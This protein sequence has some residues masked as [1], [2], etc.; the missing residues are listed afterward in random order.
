MRNCA[1]IVRY[2]CCLALPLLIPS[3]VSLAAQQDDSET[4][5]PARAE[6]AKAMKKAAGDKSSGPKRFPE[7]K[8]VIKDMK[9][10]EGLFTLYRYD[11]KDKNRDPEKLLAK[12]PARL[13]KEDMLFATS[14]SRGGSFTG[15][16]WSDHLIRW[17]IAG[18]HL[19]MIVPD[20][21]YVVKKGK[22]ISDAIKR[23]YNAR[24]I[25]TAQIVT[26]SGSDPVIDLG[27]LLKS[28]LADV[29]FMGGSIRRE[30]SKWTKTKVFPD[31]ILIDVD[32]AMSARR[33][34]GALAGLFGGGAPAKGGTTL[35]VSYTFRRLPKLGSYKPRKADDR[36]GYF[37]TAQMDLTK[38]SEARDTFDRYIN[39]WNLE[40]RD[41]SLELSPPKKPVTYIIEKTVPVQWRRWVRQGIL[42][43]NKA[44]EEIGIVDA[45]VVQQQTEDNEFA[46]YDPEDSRY[47]FFRWIVSGRAFAMGPS[48]ADPRTGQILDADIIM[49]DAMV[50]VWMTDFDVF[51]PS[52]VAEFK[53]PGFR[54]YVERHPEL[55]PDA[56]RDVFLRPRGCGEQVPAALQR[57]GDPS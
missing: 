38:K 7:F 27:A 51:A 24:F 11:P 19:K 49:D 46:K 48:R 39:R 12:I 33:G 25:A 42:E 22:P 13:L 40:K 35:G 32:L 9:A 17:E 36:V 14:I 29:S 3:S 47:N 57:A 8:E 1:R 44:F 56:L 10:T 41:P 18:K 21:N 43:W 54:E 31:N 34:G 6:L 30:L 50:R 2:G 4:Q 5:A 52:T 26:M 55:V 20:T 23:T 37:L 53:G 28:D 16:M 45:I 15:W